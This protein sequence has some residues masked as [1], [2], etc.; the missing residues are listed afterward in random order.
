MPPGGRS[1]GALRGR[2]AGSADA[3]A[4]PSVLP[5][6]AAGASALPDAAA[7]NV[8]AFVEALRTSVGRQTLRARCA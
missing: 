5:A 7:A 8:A 4:A 3:G 6:E 1:V 2:R